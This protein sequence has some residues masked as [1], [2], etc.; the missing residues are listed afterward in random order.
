MSRPFLTRVISLWD[1][2]Q[3]DISKFCTPFEA[4]REQIEEGM[5]SLRKK[6]AYLTP[7]DEVAAG[8]IVTIA[9]RSEKGKYN[10][11]SVKLNVG[12][13]LYSREIE[14]ELLSMAAGEEKD[15]TAD[16]VSVH[17]KVLK[18]ERTQLPELNDEFLSANLQTVHTM[19]ELEEWY[20]NAQLEEHIKQQ[21]AMAADHIK[22]CVL[23]NSKIDV[24]EDERLAVRA[25][26]EKIVR[27]MWVL[28]GLPLDEMTDEQA[29][30][31]LGLPSAQDYI[32]W[33]SDLSEIDI[34]NSAIGYELL[35]RDGK[36]PTE[37]DYHG[38]LRKMKEEEFIPSEQLTDYTYGAY[39]RQVCS[40]YYYDLLESYA[41]DI[42][43]EKLL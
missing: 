4:D 24:N 9:C 3:A 10:K 36:S 28:N 13:N 16:G 39:A 43:K 17:I 33:F 32:D 23:E 40:E 29:E 35:L 18:I 5:L 11:D 38:A 30:E 26:G 42:I 20:I 2:K 15:I 25:Q 19:K 37:E 41:Y 31:I 7:A 1:Y 12:K 22:G 21:A 14:A 6:H 34:S 8:D 27:D